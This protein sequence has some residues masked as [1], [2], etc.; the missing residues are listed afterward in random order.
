VPI[1]VEACNPPTLTRCNIEVTDSGMDMRSDA[2]PIE[3]RIFIDEVRWRFITELPV[4]TNFFKF[5]E[6]RIGLSQIVRIAKLTDKISSP[7][8]SPI[9][10]NFLLVDRR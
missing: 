5:V 7:Q 1:A 2:V 9:F 4:Q 10:V 6:Q 3:F 8:E